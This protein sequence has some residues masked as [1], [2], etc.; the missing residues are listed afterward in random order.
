MIFH[1]SLGSYSRH[2]YYWYVCKGWR[3]SVDYFFSYR[4]RSFEKYSFEKNEF[5]VSI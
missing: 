1:E 2:C 3:R 4:A 5:K